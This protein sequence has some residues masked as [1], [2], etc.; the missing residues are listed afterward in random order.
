[1][2]GLSLRDPASGQHRQ[3][4]GRGPADRRRVGIPSQ[5]FAYVAQLDVG[6]EGRGESGQPRLQRALHLGELA[7]QPGGLRPGRTGLA[8]QTLDLVP[9]QAVAA[10]FAGP[11]PLPVIWHAAPRGDQR[12]VAGRENVD[13]WVSRSA[14]PRLPE[15]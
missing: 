4:R 14:T 3:R 7:A 1:M 6:V 8:V 2:V 12:E 13:T 11:E 9:Q 5:L 15:L 10:T